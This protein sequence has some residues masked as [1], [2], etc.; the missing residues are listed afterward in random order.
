MAGS[1]AIAAVFLFMNKFFKITLLVLA[2]T[3]TV[4]TASHA[5]FWK[6]IFKKEEHKPVKKTNTTKP[7]S[8]KEE[9]RL[10]KKVEPEYPPSE[11]KEVYRVDVLLPLYLNTLVQNGKPVYKKVPD[12]AVGSINF[13]EGMSIAAQALKNKGMKL[14]LYV[15]DITDPLE[16]IAKLT[17]SKKLDSA[18]L[19]IGFL[20]STDIPAVAAYAKKNKTN[21]I[22]ALSPADAGTTDNPYFILLQPTLETHINQL[23]GFA[24]K[25]FSKNPK[26]I[27]HTN[28]TSGEKEAYT[29][30]KNALIEDK[31]LNI[32]DCS[33]FKLKTD[34]LAKIFDSTKVNVIFVSVLD[35][36]NTEQILNA[37]AA[38][39]RS[40]RFEIFGMPSWKSLRGLTQQSEYM[41]LSIHY[42]TPFFYDPT[43]GTGRYIT[44]EYGNTYGGAPSEMVYRGYES[45]YWMSNLLESHGT[46]FNRDI[47]DVSAAPFTRY[48]IKPSW[49]KENDF[50]YLENNKLYIL[51]YQNG[52]YVVEQQ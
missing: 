18:D 37:L 9:P 47:T 34:T 5:Q 12:Y 1:I 21:F 7:V 45:L 13:Y 24:N 2:C 52:G 39:P 42:T 14:E 20:Q 38:M 15:H 41:A 23:I 16:N 4:S 28:N 43:T 19:I 10:K 17:T 50:Q 11:R 25:K 40:Y 48:D 29:Q 51:H 27:L 44:T 33:K 26:Y 3:F 32:I 36:T 6:K 35:I 8:K 49:S 30:L 22:S 46:I 31:Y